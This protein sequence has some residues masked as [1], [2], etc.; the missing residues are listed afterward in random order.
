MRDSL[1]VNFRNDHG[2]KILQ[3]CVFGTWTPTWDC[4]GTPHDM[5]CALSLSLSHLIR[6]KH[7]VLR[8]KS[9][10]PKHNPPAAG[11]QL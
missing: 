9:H 1:L 8:I 7:K 10:H 5:L 3:N 11:V 2:A 6:R 4:S